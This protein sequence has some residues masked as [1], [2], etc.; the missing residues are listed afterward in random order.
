MYSPGRLDG[1]QAIINSSKM[2]LMRQLIVAVDSGESPGPQL[3]W[4]EKVYFVCFVLF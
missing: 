4:M 2:V 3:L 1:A